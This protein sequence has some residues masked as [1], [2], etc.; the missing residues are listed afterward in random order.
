MLMNNMETKNIVQLLQT[1]EFCYSPDPI[2]PFC[3]ACYDGP[4]PIKTI[5]ENNKFLGSI[6]PVIQEKIS[7]KEEFQAVFLPHQEKPIS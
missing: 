7:E 1:N 2:I 4:K 3:Q 6:S 5:Q